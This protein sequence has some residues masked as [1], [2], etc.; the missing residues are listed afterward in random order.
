MRTFLMG[1]SGLVA[2]SLIQ[3]PLSPPEGGRGQGRKRHSRAGDHLQRA[4]CACLLA[5]LCAIAV[6][7]CLM[8]HLSVFVRRGALQ[9]SRKA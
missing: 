3:M 1:L 9:E 2:V 5:K 4:E 7:C 8:L 6:V